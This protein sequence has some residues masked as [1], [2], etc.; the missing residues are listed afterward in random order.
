M[1]DGTAASS[2]WM[3]LAHRIPVP[4][5]QS[6]LSYMPRAKIAGPRCAWACLEQLETGLNIFQIFQYL[7]SK[8][9]SLTTE[10]QRDYCG[11]VPVL[12]YSDV[13]RCCQT[14][15]SQ[16]SHIGNGFLC[17][18]FERILNKINSSHSQ[19]IAQIGPMLVAFM[20]MCVYMSICVCVCVHV[21]VCGMP[22][23]KSLAI[24]IKHPT[25]DTSSHKK[26]DEQ[27]ICRPF[28]AVG[29]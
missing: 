22:W 24:A 7:Q 25:L 17:E 14:V 28:L 27:I 5:Q 12:Y 21:R 13:A 4:Q 1:A 2:N 19:A 10:H 15:K 11:H 16:F 3:Q 26:L 18:D 9:T 29:K 20:Q 6:H 23:M 8:L